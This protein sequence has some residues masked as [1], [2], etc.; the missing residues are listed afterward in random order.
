MYRMRKMDK[1]AI[2]IVTYN[3]K[4]LL[5]ECVINALN[6][7]IPA[8]KIVIVNNASTDDTVEYLKEHTFE[9]ERFEIIHCDKNIGGAGG[10]CRGMQIALNYNVDWM[11]VID[12][13]AILNTDYAEKILIA[14]QNQEDYQAAAGIVMTN[15]SV[16]KHHRRRVSKYGMLLKIL[17]DSYYQK[18]TFSCDIASFCGMMVRKELV[19][20]IGVPHSDY[21][22]FHDDTEYSLRILKYSKFLVVTDAI[23]DHKTK[24]TIEKLP[25][26]YTWKDYYEIRN[27]LLYVREHGNTFDVVVNNLDIFVHKVFRNWVFGIIS[28]DGYDW[29]YE[30]DLVKKA[31]KNATGGELKNVIIKRER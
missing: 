22:I 23:L 17:D 7:T 31:I 10:F 21:F 29:K 11:L 2:I 3:R 1:Y 19:E 8:Y 28:R 5:E 30:K 20:R 18:A 26:R 25:R 6:Q 24:P 16:D 9:N 27:R 12:D 13:D 4:A 15:G 14:L